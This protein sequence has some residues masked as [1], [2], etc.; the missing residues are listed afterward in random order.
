MCEGRM[1]GEGPPAG[2]ERAAVEGAISVFTASTNGPRRMGPAIGSANLRDQLHRRRTGAALEVSGRMATGPTA[3]PSSRRRGG[4]VP[5]VRLG[6]APVH[7]GG[8]S[9]HRS[10]ARGAAGAAGAAGCAVASP[11]AADPGTQAAGRGPLEAR[12]GTSGVADPRAATAAGVGR[13]RRCT[14]AGEIVPNGVP[15]AG[16]MVRRTPEMAPG[17]ANRPVTVPVVPRSSGNGRSARDSR[18]GATT[19]AATRHAVARRGVPSR[20][21]G[22]V[23]RCRECASPRAAWSAMPADATGAKGARG[24]GAR[25]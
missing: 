2:I 12:S 9:V 14:T 11:G 13:G 19:R 25:T 6:G 18:R 3:E 10:S 7:A 23:R 17:P 15:L 22:S 1:I 5:L 21:G 8:S 20:C 4:E 24:D 16:A